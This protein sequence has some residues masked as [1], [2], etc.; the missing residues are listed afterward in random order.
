MSRLWVPELSICIISLAFCSPM[1]TASVNA[2]MVDGCWRMTSQESLDDAL[3]RH[4]I[5]GTIFGRGH[6]R[7]GLP[8]PCLRVQKVASSWF[9]VPSFIPNRCVKWFIM[10]SKLM[11]SGWFSSHWRAMPVSRFS[12]NIDANSGVTQPIL[13]ELLKSFTQS[14]ASVGLSLENRGS[15]KSLSPGVIPNP[16]LLSYVFFD[17]ATIAEREHSR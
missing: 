8:F 17:R 3:G 13:T 6:C 1:A 10:S 12:S 9:L 4:G 14:S 16:L 5:Q 11:L 15:I 7:T 2:S